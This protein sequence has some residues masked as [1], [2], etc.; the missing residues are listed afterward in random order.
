MSHWA[1]DKVIALS[2]SRRFGKHFLS[3]YREFDLRLLHSGEQFTARRH[4]WRK[5]VS[6]L[7][8]ASPRR[9]R[10]LCGIVTLSPRSP[11]D[12]VR[13]YLLFS[14]HEKQRERERPVSLRVWGLAN[15]VVCQ[16]HEP[17]SWGQ[18]SQCWKAGKG[19]HLRSVSLPGN[20]YSEF[21]SHNNI[22]FKS[23]EL[24]IQS[25]RPLCQNHWPP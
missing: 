7:N 24:V 22:C 17:V 23:V 15:T 18:H 16:Q 20:S 6:D 12:C 5:T 25:K 21:I 2:S 8:A 3:R 4:C 9:N 13:V 11:C 1:K 14:R 19:W 10:N